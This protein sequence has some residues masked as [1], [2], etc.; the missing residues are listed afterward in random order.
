MLSLSRSRTVGRRFGVVVFCPL[1]VANL[2]GEHPCFVS[3]SVYV[4][5]GSSRICPT[6]EY[7]VPGGDVTVAH[8]TNLPDRPGLVARNH[9]NIGKPC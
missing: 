9:H 2:A 8:T 3:F 4:R 7:I 1:F 6:C 5:T